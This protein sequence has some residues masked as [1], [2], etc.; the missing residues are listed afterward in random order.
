LAARAFRGRIDELAI[1]NRVLTQQEITQMVDA[2][3]P[4]VLW[5]KE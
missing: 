1:W 2:G 5:S 4:G 3:R